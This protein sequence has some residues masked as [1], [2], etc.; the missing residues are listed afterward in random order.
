MNKELSKNAQEANTYQRYVELGGI[1][2][3]NDYNSAFEKA[4]KKTVFNAAGVKQAEEIARYAGI[5]LNGTE[6]SPDKMI[7]LYEVLRSDVNS[8]ISDIRLF[9]EALRMLGEVDA[10]NKLKAKYHTNRPAGTYCP[11]CGQ[12][13][14]NEDCPS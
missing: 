10:L 14:Y 13:R 5:D 8:D 6:G 1:I 2:N 11:I 7:A 12:T 3:E 4:Q 9:R